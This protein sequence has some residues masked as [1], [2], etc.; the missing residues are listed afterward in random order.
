MSCHGFSTGHW[1][2]CLMHYQISL[3]HSPCKG[4]HR[5]WNWI[6]TR[7]TMW[8]RMYSLESIHPRFAK[9]L[10]RFN[11][12]WHF[13]D[14]LVEELHTVMGTSVLSSPFYVLKGLTIQCHFTTWKCQNEKNVLTHVH[15]G[16]KPPFDQ[17]IKSLSQK[18]TLFG[19]LGFSKKVK[20]VCRKGQKSKNELTYLHFGQKYPFTQEIRSLAQKLSILT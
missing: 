16:Q 20:N 15:V 6:T 3:Y 14:L 9:F 7:G 12:H 2:G 17:K 13:P 11:P 8:F 19:F 18:R 4:A 1:N 10:D 5:G